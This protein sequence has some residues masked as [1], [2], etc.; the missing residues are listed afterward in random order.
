MPSSKLL[1]ILPF[2]G[3]FSVSFPFFM[4]AA[5]RCF[6]P[7]LLQFFPPQHSV[8]AA[9]GFRR[10]GQ[11]GQVDFVLRSEPGALQ[12]FFKMILQVSANLCVEGIL[13]IHVLDRHMKQIVEAL[14]QAEA[15]SFS[16]QHRV[17][18]DDFPL[19][20]VSVPDDIDISAGE[21]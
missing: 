3:V 14:I 8:H 10:G 4:A 13:R 7:G 1:G 6:F 2:Y 11:Q 15:D 21:V 16:L 9:H 19:H 18:R 5:R 20:C 12:H 17:D